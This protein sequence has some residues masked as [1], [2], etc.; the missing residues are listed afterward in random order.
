MLPPLQLQAINTD[1]IDTNIIAI[2]KKIMRDYLQD[3]E[4]IP[5]NNL[6][7]VSYKELEKSPQAVLQNYIYSFGT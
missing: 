5:A 7:E 6:V 2:Y 1:Q 3:K 4:K